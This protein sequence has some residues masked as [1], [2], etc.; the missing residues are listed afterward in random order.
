MSN[1]AE[2]SGGSLPRR[3]HAHPARGGAGVLLLCSPG[4]TPH[5]G[6]FSRKT[7]KEGERAEGFMAQNQVLS[8]LL[9]ESAQRFC[10]SLEIHREQW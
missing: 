1:E 3:P 2:Q 7:P 8:L 6:L 4:S 9:G 5:N 10:N